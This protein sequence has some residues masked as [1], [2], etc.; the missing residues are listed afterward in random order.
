MYC[1][2][3]V[4]LN[5]QFKYLDEVKRGRKGYS[6]GLVVQWLWWFKWEHFGK[7]CIKVDLCS[8]FMWPSRGLIEWIRIILPGCDRGNGLTI[9]APSHQRG[10]TSLNLACKNDL[11]ADLSRLFNHCLRSISAND[12]WSGCWNE[13]DTI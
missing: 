5:K 1:N 6:L 7:I 10:R 12:S 11:W 4:P 2:G 13:I 9:S 3:I 8:V